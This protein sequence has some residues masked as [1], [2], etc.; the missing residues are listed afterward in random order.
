MYYIIF[1]MVLGLWIIAFNYARA[2]K[3]SNLVIVLIITTLFIINR[4]NQDYEAYVDI[5]NVNELYAEI[6]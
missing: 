5:F 1:V 3:L 2:N 4:Q 6:G